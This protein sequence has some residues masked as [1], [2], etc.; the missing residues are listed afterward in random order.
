M[1]IR[2]FI[3]AA[4]VSGLAQSAL[5]QNTENTIDCTEPANAEEEVCLA[6]PDDGVTNFV[7]L[8]AP[9][10][11]ALGAGALAA[12]GGGGGSTPSTPSTTN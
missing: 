1:S 9:V 10:L 5:A 6:L 3:A 7:P 2:V 12:A 8:V 4:V 11:G